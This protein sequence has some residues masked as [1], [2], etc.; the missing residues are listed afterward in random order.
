[1]TS[2]KD[3]LFK[4]RRKNVPKSCSN[5]SDEKYKFTLYCGTE[6]RKLYIVFFSS[7]NTT[8]TLNLLFLLQNIFLNLVISKSSVR[9]VI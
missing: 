7:N 3:F 2:L 5:E 6:Q 9:C 4:N 1:M 8:D